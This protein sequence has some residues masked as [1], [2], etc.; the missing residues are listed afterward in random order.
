LSVIPGAAHLANIEQ[1]DRV[2]A[3]LLDHLLR[4]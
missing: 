3:V 1:A 2:N 4:P